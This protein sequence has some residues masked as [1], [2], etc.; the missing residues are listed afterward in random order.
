MSSRATDKR[1]GLTLLETFGG[2]SNAG[3]SKGDRCHIDHQRKARATSRQW[4]LE[5]PGQEGLKPLGKKN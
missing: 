4:R 3:R 1:K 2:V 5:H